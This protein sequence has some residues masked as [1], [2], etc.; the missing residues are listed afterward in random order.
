MRQ[1][2][3]ATLSILLASPCIVGTAWASLDLDRALALIPESATGFVAWP[4]PKKSNADCIGMLEQLGVGGAMIA[5][6]PIDLFKAQFG[7]GANFDESA[8]VIAYFIGKGEAATMVFVIGSTDP[9]AFM[10]ANMTPAGDAALGRYTSSLGMIV[11]A[12]AV[13]NN[14]I[15]SPSADAVAGYDAS[16]PMGARF[17]ARLTSEEWNSLDRADLVYWVEADAMDALGKM[18]RLGSEELPIVAGSN[19]V[20]AAANFDSKKIL[21]QLSDAVI[22]IDIDPL[23]VWLRTI[24]IAREGS[25]LAALTAARESSTSTKCLRLPGNPFYLAASIDCVGLGG[26]EALTDS[27]ELMNI[28]R[29]LLPEWIVSDGAAITSVQFAA[30]PSKLGVAV[31]GVLN[32][33]ALFI[34]SKN[35]EGTLARMKASFLALKG[36]D[37]GVKRDPQWNDAKTLKSGTIANAFELKETITDMSQMPEGSEYMRL[38]KQF[39]VGVRGLVGLAAVKEGGVVVTFSQRPD[40]FTRAMA[41]GVAGGDAALASDAT[42]QSIEEW[43]PPKRDAEIFL[44]VGRLAMLATSIMSGVGNVFGAEA[45]AAAP[46]IPT[47]DPSME[48]LALSLGLGDGRIDGVLVVPTGVLKYFA[49]IYASRNESPAEAAKDDAEGDADENTE[50]SSAQ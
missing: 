6:R 32:D 12:R 19:A 9:A 28:D 42:L 15:M 4:S 18:M 34:A 13:G 24:S 38:G 36:E 10:Q 50:D 27:M 26:V 35:P 25:A 8:P 30:Y 1:I 11:S 47:P 41:A 48:P 3:A 22:A 46:S 44:G 43:L 23:G 40:V 21:E 37:G 39:V 2:F 5:G 16:K 17:Q 29:A 20:T 14:V 7:I 31:G 45:G 49:A 33:S